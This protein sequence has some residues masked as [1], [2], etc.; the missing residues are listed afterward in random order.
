MSESRNRDDAVR[1]NDESSELRERQA[2]AVF[3]L[4]AGHAFDALDPTDPRNAAFF[5]W[6]AREL[7]ERQTTEERRATARRAREF[8]ARL[9]R[10]WAEELLGVRSVLA[11]PAVRRA[12]V[13]ATAAQALELAAPDAQAPYLDLAVAAGA[14]RELWDEECAEWLDIPQGL[15]VG[16]HLALRVAGESMTPF[17]HDGDTLLVKV[18]SELTPGSVVVARRPD[19]GYVVK[20]VG[21]VRKRSVE[22]VSLNP[23][24]EPI[25]LPRDQR[26]LLGTVVLR[27]CAHG[28]QS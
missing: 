3:R 24:F 18:G 26:L 20:R 5:D 8:A 25:H 16:K 13:T 10:R 6:Y 2:D 28:A 4:A 15:P 22:L 19:D 7:R 21:Q 17:L 23:A 1:H 27:W 9:T 11:T 14:G 12:P